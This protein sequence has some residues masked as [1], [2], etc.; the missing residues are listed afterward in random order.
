[1]LRTHRRLKQGN[2]GPPQANAGFAPLYLFLIEEPELYLHPQ[3]ERRRMVELKEL[4]DD[5]NA[6]VVLC[7]HSAI[8]VDLAE[9]KGIH[10]FERPGRNATN[11][12][13]WTGPDLDADPVRTISLANRFN[14]YRSAM[15]FADLVILVE[16]ASEQAA[17]PHVA[18]KLGLT[19]A[20]I[21][22]EVVA[23]DGN[24]KI[25]PYQTVLEGL[26]IKYVAWFDSDDQDQVK[27][28]KTIRSNA[29]GKIITTD[30]DWEQM[31]G[32]STSSKNKVYNSWK[33]FVFDDNDPNDKLKNRV[34]AAY[35]WRDEE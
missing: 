11:V 3:A 25:P 24:S 2:G 19:T 22:V 12:I 9:Y 5:D 28:G 16:G 35:N 4:A 30:R 26:G 27:E 10:R 21:D 17:I 6:Q 23:C 15:V 33:F 20:D 32:L 29:F 13:S 18:E 31:N 14:I 7:T 8:F 34:T 1:M